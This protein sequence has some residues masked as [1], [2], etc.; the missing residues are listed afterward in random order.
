M[1]DEIN[2]INGTL[3]NH[4]FEALAQRFQEEGTDTDGDGLADEWRVL[5][6]VV[7]SG[8]CATKAQVVGFAYFTITEVRPAPDKEVVGTLECGL[9]APDSATGGDDF[10]TRASHPKLV[11]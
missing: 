6:P 5:L 10:G 8:G 1:G 4:T 3:S 2:V 7:E 11:H 9:V